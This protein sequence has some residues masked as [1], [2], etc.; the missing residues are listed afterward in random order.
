MSLLKSTG[1]CLHSV[2]YDFRLL[3]TSLSG[4]ARIAIICT[5]SPEARHGIESVS[6]LKFAQ[7]ASTIVTKAEQGIIY[8]PGAL[9][10]EYEETIANLQSQLAD[11][12][13]NNAQ[14][15]PTMHIEALEEERRK[16]EQAEKEAK[17]YSMSVISLQSQIDHLKA[18]MLTGS[19]GAPE[20]AGGMPRTPSM[21][22]RNYGDIGSGS[23]PGGVPGS[24]RRLSEMAFGIGS[25]LKS[26]GLPASS[27]MRSISSALE[28]MPVVKDDSRVRQL[29]EELAS[30]RLALEKEQSTSRK[31]IEDVEAESAMYR[32]RSQEAE[33]ELE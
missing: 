9:I 33:A 31:K 12:R 17:D 10:A 14:S 30:M 11:A 20:S 23:R 3:Q 8:G 13:K 1:S 19:S 21:A 18:L 5:I 29:E 25:P 16:R 22:K 27:S 28:A 32:A 15:Q 4:N 2:T 26:V 6:T 24:H 7:R